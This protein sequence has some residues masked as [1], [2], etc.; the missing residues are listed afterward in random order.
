MPSVLVPVS[1]PPLDEQAASASAGM[2]ASIAMPLMSF[3]FFTK[4]SFG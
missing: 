3:V 1:R 2:Q 4:I